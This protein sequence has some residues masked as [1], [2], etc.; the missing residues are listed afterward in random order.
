MFVRCVHNI[1]WNSFTS[2]NNLNEDH[3]EFNHPSTSPQKYSIWYN[4]Y[5][6]YKW[7]MKDSAT[8]ILSLP[9]IPTTTMDNKMAVTEVRWSGKWYQ[10][11]FCGTHVS[12][13]GLSNIYQKRVL[14]G[15]I[16]PLNSVMHYFRSAA[17]FTAYL[18]LRG[19]HAVEE[20]RTLVFIYDRCTHFRVWKI[21]WQK[22][23]G[24][25]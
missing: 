16:P 12:E 2:F 9:S 19:K 25:E 14:S 3:C 15:V 10:L 21:Q 24:R 20:V 5:W 6:C 4:W 1:F 8:V 11:C 18:Y 22:V 13:G 17:R 7:F 23:A